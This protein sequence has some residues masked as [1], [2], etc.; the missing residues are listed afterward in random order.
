MLHFEA[1]LEVAYE[2]SSRL[3][4]LHYKGGETLPV[5]DRDQTLSQRS[6]HKTGWRSMVKAF[7]TLMKVNDQELICC[8]E[9]IVPPI[10]TSLWL[11]EQSSYVGQGQRS[12]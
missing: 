2:L 5:I 1:E 3:H 6:K 12:R 9:V 4:Y 10:N 7:K 11:Y 8:Q